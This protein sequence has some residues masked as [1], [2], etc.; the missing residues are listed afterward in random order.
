MAL[1]LSASMGHE[2]VVKE[3]LRHNPDLTRTLPIFGTYAAI[4]KQHDYPRVAALLDQARRKQLADQRAARTKTAQ[5]AKQTGTSQP[6]PARN[7]VQIYHSNGRV[8]VVR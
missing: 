2:D 4:A 5:T 7:S 8:E 1:F 3:L 6:T